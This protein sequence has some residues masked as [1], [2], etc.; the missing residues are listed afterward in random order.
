MA[1]DTYTDKTSSQLY[2]ITHIPT[3]LVYHRLL[4]ERGKDSS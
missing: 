1:T 4:L 2:R 3:G